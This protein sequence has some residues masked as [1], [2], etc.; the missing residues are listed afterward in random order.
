MRRGGHLAVRSAAV[1]VAG[2][3]ALALLR[4]QPVSP[5]ATPASALTIRIERGAPGQP[6]S[7]PLFADP[8][9]DARPVSGA[10]G[11]P[12]LL[13]IVGRLSDPLVMLRGA[14]GTIRT[15]P[16]GT[17]IGGW[18][19]VAVAGDRVTF[20]RGAEERVAVLPMQDDAR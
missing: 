3:G 1:L 18:T 19:L 10:G 15:V 12:Q 9:P 20:R 5:V 6:S 16:P 7:A 17:A 14:D 2:L 11:P 4:H 13:G 8:A